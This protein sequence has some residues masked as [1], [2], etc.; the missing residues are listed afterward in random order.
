MPDTASAAANKIFRRLKGLRAHMQAHE[1]PILA[2]PAIWDSGSSSHSTACDV[3][4]TNQRLLGYYYRSFPRERIFIETINLADIGTV[5][6]RKKNYEPIF[7]EI[8]VSDGTHKV[9][10]RTPQQKSVLLYDTLHTLTEHNKRSDKQ[11]EASI[12]TSSDKERNEP[13]ERNEPRAEQEQIQTSEH[14]APVYGREEVIRPFEKTPLAVTSLLVGGILL[15]LIGIVLLLNT[16]N[17]S[18]SIPL[19]IA[20]FVAVGASFLSRMTNK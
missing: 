12:E 7:R 19:F 3:I 16:H 14:Q 2:L 9:Y 8:L 13:E 10:I 17:A 4:V 5:V 15:E 1:E 11:N 6:W 18:I 20:G